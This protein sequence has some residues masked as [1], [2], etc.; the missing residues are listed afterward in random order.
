MSDVTADERAA[1]DL[2][3]TVQLRFRSRQSVCDVR[4]TRA[5]GKAD[6][7]Q[8]WR[9]QRRDLITLCRALRAL[10]ERVARGRTAGVG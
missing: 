1:E 6:A 10:Q 2:L 3:V 5:M 4:G 9:W 7:M 8:R